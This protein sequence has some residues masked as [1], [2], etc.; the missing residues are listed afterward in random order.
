MIEE[1]YIK[2]LKSL[3]GVEKPLGRVTFRD[4]LKWTA[5][6][7]FIYYAMTQISIVGIAPQSFQQFQVFQIILGSRFG[8]LMTLGIGPIVTA[9]IILQLLVGSKIIPWDL[10]SEN[11][12][13]LFQGT[14]K[15]LAILFCFLEA[16]I[17]V[18][19]G[20][21]PPLSPDWTFLV[22]IQLAIGGVLV[23]FMDELISKWGFGSGVS[24]FIVAGVTSTIIQ[25]MLNPF[26]ACVTDEFGG[27]CLSI[28]AQPRSTSIT[29]PSANNPPLGR[30]PQFI[31]YLGMADIQNAM[32]SLI[33]VMATVLVFLL[34]I[35]INAIKVE[36]PLA[37]GSVRGFGRRWPLRFLYTSNIPVILVGALLANFQWM[38]RSLSE[39]GLT[40]LGMYDANGAVTG[41]LAFYLSAPRS[42]AL[43]GFAISIGFFVLL[44]VVFAY[45]TKKKAW[46]TGIIFAILGGI[47]WYLA[48]L[49]TGATSLVSIPAADMMRALSYTMFMVVGAAIFSVFWMMTS[50]MDPHSVATQIYSTGMQIPGFRRDIRIIERVLNRYIPALAILGG[51]SVGFLAAFADFTNALGTGTGILLSTMIIHQLYEEIAM[52]H[53]EDMH[54]ALRK[55]MGR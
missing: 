23:I 40:W 15:L 48:A 12:R 21:I 18:T 2:F 32:L 47:F 11:G 49:S 46:K 14:Q 54:P 7:L 42:D 53:M 33:P 30:I 4:K 39:K 6:V 25:G 43:S 44:G 8:S 5:L 13:I 41:G 24:L 27:G 52:Q 31:F 17:F 45:F 10:S 29:F 28:F 34:V 20:T 9:S 1:G 22:V 35:Y 16:M 51:A 3:P 50:G 36:I 37:F 55:F 26:A 19:M 38:A